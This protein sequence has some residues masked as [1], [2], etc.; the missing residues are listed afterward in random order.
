MPTQPGDVSSDK[1]VFSGPTEKSIPAGERLPGTGIQYIGPTTDKGAEMRIDGQTAFKQRA[2]S[3]IWKGSPMPGVELS[4]NMRVLTFNE[5]KLRM[6]G[7]AT[8]VIDNPNPTPLP[9]PPSGAIEYVLPVTYNVDV[10]QTAPGTTLTLI[11]I[12]PEKGAQFSGWSAEQY[13]YRR[14]ADSVQWDG[15]LRQ[16]VGLSLNTR[17]ALLEDSVQLVGFATISLNP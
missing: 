11:A 15:Q 4:L 16:G 10:G 7:L 3:V 2:D 8:I 12:D 13:P 14:L 5:A 1:L 6:A 9:A 17:V